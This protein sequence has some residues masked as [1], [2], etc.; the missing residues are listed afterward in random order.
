[1][2]MRSKVFTGGRFTTLTAL[3]LLSTDSCHYLREVVMSICHYSDAR[4]AWFKHK[5]LARLCID[6][7]S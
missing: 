2:D 1:M 5:G 7:R 3:K 6:T 4:A